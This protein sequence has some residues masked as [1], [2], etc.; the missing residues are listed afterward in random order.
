[1]ASA[2]P[3]ETYALNEIKAPP[4]VQSPTDSHEQNRHSLEGIGREEPSEHDASHWRDRVRG[5]ESPFPWRHEESETEGNELPATNHQ[6]LEY[7]GK[8]DDEFEVANRQ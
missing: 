3:L 4:P 6:D 5:R 2:S 7:V 1:M 8:D